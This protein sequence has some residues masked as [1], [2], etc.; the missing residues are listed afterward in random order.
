LAKYDGLMI[1]A[2]HTKFESPSQEQALLNFVADGKGFIPVHCASYCFI[3][4]KPYVELVGAQFRSHTTGVFRVRPGA[5]HPV[6][7]GFTSFESWDETYLHHKHNDKDRTVLEYRVEGEVKEPWTWVRTPG[8][9]RVFYTAWGHDHRTWSHP[10]FHNLL[11]R[12]VRWACGQ[13]PALAG[14]YT[15]APKMTA[16]TAKESDFEF[17]PAKV[18]FYPAGKSWGTTA[19]PIGKMPKPL[20]PEKSVKH[21]SVPEGFEMRLFASE[22]QFAGGKPLAMT[23]DERG[24]LWV[25]VTVDYPNE[26]RTEKG[27]DKIVILEDTD[28]DGKADKTTVFAEGLSIATSLLPVF[29][30]VVVH[31]APHTLFLKDTDGDGQADLKQTLFTG[32]GTGDT[33][34]GPSNLRYG[35]DGWVYGMCGYSGFNGTVAGEAMRFGQGFHR[36]KVEREP[37]DPHKVKVA[38]LEFLRSTNNNSWGVGFTEEGHLLGSTANGC[39]VVHLTIPNRYYERVRGLTPSVLQNIA[40]SNA[41]HP[42]TEKVRQVDWHG[43]FT[44]AA[45]LSVY[46]ARAYPPEYWNKAAFVS[47][48]TGHLTAAFV[49]Q[50]A[51]A[52]YVAR[53][54][55]NL[56][57]ADDEWAAPIDAQVGPD[58]MVW[59]LDWYNYI[60]QHNPTPQGFKTGKGAAYETELRDKKHGRIYRLVYTGA[61][62]EP[63]VDLAKASPA[64]LVEALEEL[65]MG[66]R[67]HAPRLLIDRLDPS[68]VPALIKLVAAREEGRAEY[69]EAIHAIRVLG[70]YFKKLPADLAEQASAAVGEATKHPWQP[71]RRHA[72]EVMELSSDFSKWLHHVKLFADADPQTRLAAYLKLCDCQPHNEAAK[73]IW[74]RI[75]A[76]ADLD[77]VVLG[78]A[79]T[80]AAAAHAPYLVANATMTLVPPHPSALRLL[81]TISNNLFRVSDQPAFNQLIL[82]LSL[83]QR[84]E[85]VEAVLAGMSRNWPEKAKVNWTAESTDAIK[86]LL[87]KLSVAGQVRAVQFARASGFPGL[88][89]QTQELA[90]SLLST[91]TNASAADADRI[92]AARQAIEFQ[93]ADDATAAG[94]L[95]ALD[96]KPSP[97]LAAGLIDALSQSTA[98]TIGP[99]V[100][101]KVPALP[102]TVRP[103]ALRL[104][105]GR[106]ETAKAFLDAVEAGKLRFDMLALDQKTAL[107][108]HPDAAIAGRA[109]KLLAAG[110]GLPDADRQKVIDQF[111][112]ILTVSGDAAAGKKAFVTHCAK[113][114]KHGGEGQTIGPDLTGFAVHPKEEILIHLLDPSRSVEGNYKAY[115]ATLADGRVVTGLLASESKTTI[116]LLDAENKRHPIQRDDLESLKESPKSLMP[117][118]FEKQMSRQELVDLMEFLTRKGKWVPVPL[119]KFATAVSTRGMFTRDDA[120]VER[121]VFRDWSPKVFDGVP[122]VLTDPNGD[123][124]KNVILLNGPNGHLPPT[125]PKS[126]A[127]PYSGKAVA[128]HLLSGVAGW[129]HPYGDRDTVSLIVRFR[130]ADG[131]T[132]EHRLRNG[133]HFADYIRRVDVPGSKFA[134]LLNGRQIRYLSVKPRKTDPLAGI[135]LVKGPNDTAPVVMALTVETPEP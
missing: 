83:S 12:G 112:A 2:N 45:G 15:D 14:P 119:D 67:R 33:H 43:G 87:P 95:N 52:D 24:R 97:Q 28:G 127:I 22:G 19:E 31:Q 23:W 102:P 11:E 1:F 91:V 50:P 104:V 18:P 64:E 121:L 72:M 122:F 35:F 66:G 58:G 39:P 26:L 49:L 65:N 30:G 117:E 40:L 47:D 131:T 46:T 92:A 42:I 74:Q 82:M 80:L 63:R 29:G 41:Y 70:A 53:Y 55:W 99:A 85:V 100:V 21:Y 125:M 130:Y 13:D 132:E 25:S 71:V 4:S 129:A 61:K 118:G 7:K 106:A 62:P 9:S 44:S 133:T 5:E 101:A 20:P 134:Y 34:A 105:L 32:W 135:E 38:K 16:I 57:A 3:D 126:I 78:D 48:P 96:T 93:P 36:F 77:D 17:V 69:P 124:T 90:R 128:V 51:G 6:T 108:A 37:G 10:G 60:V 89:S 8:Q 81:T 116:E 27:R 111:H 103:A 110:G 75:H 115:T 79:A 107:A 59:V 73:L 88:D 113:C 114:H 120:P 76:G 98:A 86:R 56:V 94:L 109:K 68:V 54:G 84:P 123:K